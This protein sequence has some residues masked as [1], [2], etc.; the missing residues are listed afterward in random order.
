MPLLAD[1]TAALVAG[2][3]TF[4]AARWYA[5]STVH[6]GAAD[7]GSRARGRRGGEAAPRSAAAL[8]RRLD[9]SVA[10][11]LLLTL[12]LSITLLGGLVLGVLA[13]LVRRVALIQHLDNSVA[14]WG[15]DH[16]S[17]DST[18][19]LHALTD[20][21][22]IRIVVVLA[23][24]LVVVDFDPHA[25][26]LDVP[27]PAHRARWAWKCR[28]SPS[29]ISWDAFG[30][31]STRRRRRSARRSRAATPRPRPPSMPRRRWSSARS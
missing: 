24:L 2:L 27:L 9:R 10:T 6:A 30:R 22:N 16:R 14:A 3:A 26:P 13:V 11:G 7:R 25:E 8:V 20:L 17:S 1:L 29:R 5:R 15:F 28:C 12:A 18:S 21:G 19:G 31:P 23:L 4:L